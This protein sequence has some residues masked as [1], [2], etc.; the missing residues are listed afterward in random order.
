MADTTGTIDAN[1]EA[2]TLEVDG[3]NVA[4]F[5]LSGTWLGTL[6]FEA[7]IDGNSYSPLSVL[8]ADPPRS[9][10]TA[11]AGNGTFDANVGSWS[12]VRV[13][14]TSFA[15]GSAS[16]SIHAAQ[17][18]DPPFNGLNLPNAGYVRFRSA[19]SLHDRRALSMNADNL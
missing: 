17:D 9:N 14:A 15:S 16:V 6:V 18:D 7:S 4:Q 13:R 10:V 12:H 2:V 8:T 19:D 3:K 11:V 5:N 1:G